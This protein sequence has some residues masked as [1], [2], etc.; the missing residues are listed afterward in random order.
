MASIEQ[1]KAEGLLFAPTRDGHALPVIDLTH[2]RFF[3]PDDPAAI[4][5]LRERM[6]REEGKM[7][8]L[9]R[10]LLR[11][12]MRRAARQSKL[13]QALF[14]PGTDFL[15]GLSTYVMK[16]GAENLVPPFD[17]PA[18]RRFAAT[19]HLVLLRLRMQQVARLL[20]DGLVRDLPERPAA[21]LHFINIAGG[22][23]MDSINAVIWLQQHH[24]DLLRRPIRIHV[25][26]RDDAGPW[27]GARALETLKASSA[28]LAG[29]DITV[30]HIRYDW[31]EAEILQQFTAS[32]DRNAIIAAS[33]EGGL[34]EYGD[35]AMVVANLKA[36]RAGG[37][38]LVAG[39]VTSGDPA[40]RRMV[41]SGPFRLFPR[42][43]AGFTPLAHA[44][45][46]TIERA[47][48]VILSEQLLLRPIPDESNPSDHI[49]NVLGQGA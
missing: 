44:A 40:R 45:G 41:A 4:A 6:V 15:D 26:D 39:S 47:E 14:H 38:T 42:G 48:S 19:P 24:A 3:V 5:G 46:F 37:A 12:I 22:P 18:D 21:P 9:P 32:L 34:F 2:P 13:M 8:R 31:R 25:L 29:L 36:L 27:F 43:M 28:P 23:A 10:F 7:R 30:V 16:L 35:D 20:A 17:S 33:S 1:L 49:N 11:W